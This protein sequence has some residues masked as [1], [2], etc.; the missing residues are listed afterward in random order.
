MNVLYRFTFTDPPPK[1]VIHTRFWYSTRL[2][3]SPS[4]STPPSNPLRLNG[5]MTRQD[6][7][8][9][10]NPCLWGH[11]MC[12]TLSEMSCVFGDNGKQVFGYYLLR[13]TSILEDQFSGLFPVSVQGKERQ[14]LY[15]YSLI[16]PFHGHHDQCCGSNKVIQQ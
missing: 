12:D 3:G 15:M 2:P 9:M 16:S 8:E 1:I 7:Q 6:S 11:Q 5:G 10:S 14:T 13:Q 4:V